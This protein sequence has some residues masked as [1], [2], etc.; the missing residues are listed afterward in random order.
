ADPALPRRGA[1]GRARLKTA[2]ESPA[3][4]GFVLPAEWEPHEAV[5][6]GW[7]HNRSDWPGRF[8]PIPWGY[9]AMTRWIAR[10]ET[11]RI[12]VEARPHES[13]AR[14]LLKRLSADLSRVE[15][16]RFRTDRGWTRDSGPTFVRLRGASPEVAISRFRFSGWAKYPDWKK[17]SRMADRI[18]RILGV[19][20]FSDGGTADPV[21]E[22]GSID[23]NGRG[24]PLTAE[25][26]LLDPKVQVR[27]P[28]FGRADYEGIF[29][30]RLGVTNVLWLG[31]GIAGDDT[32]GHVDDICRFVSP[33]A[34]VLC[35]ERNGSDDNHA[36]LEE[37]R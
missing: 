18:A 33:T 25:E 34:V 36:P 13:S 14:R 9:G 5:W 35:A 3:S 32:H 28:G 23:V 27:N 4:A 31:R 22:G 6:I 1:V 21:L 17:D 7:P 16:L 12:I 10:R 19:R 8:G 2:G 30:E 37:N 29:R 20:V 26:C 24:T 11:V 15:F